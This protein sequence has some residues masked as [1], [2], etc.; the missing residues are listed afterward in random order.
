ML[1]ISGINTSRFQDCGIGSDD[2]DSDD[3][4]AIYI[5]GDGELF[6]ELLIYKYISRSKKLSFGAWPLWEILGAEGLEMGLVGKGK[7][8]AVASAVAKG[9]EMI[10]GAV[11]IEGEQTV[12][13]LLT[14]AVAGEET[15]CKATFGHLYLRAEHSER[16]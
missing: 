11:G 2:D 6:T 9:G 8:L 10:I 13:L 4:E 14:I 1:A 16:G 5:C 15:T 12:Y 7:E 3:S